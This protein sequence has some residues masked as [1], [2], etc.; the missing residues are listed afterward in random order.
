MPDDVA[1]VTVRYGT[2]ERSFTVKDNFYGYEIAVGAERQP[3]AVFWTLAQRRAPEV[4]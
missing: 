4:R 2:S 1:T 3:D